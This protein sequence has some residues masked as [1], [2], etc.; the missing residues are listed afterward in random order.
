VKFKYRLQP[1]AKLETVKKMLESPS[2]TVKN[3]EMDK[4]KWATFDLDVKD[5]TKLNTTALFKNVAVTITDGADKGTKVLTAKHVNA[6]PMT[7]PEKLRDYYGNE[8][9]VTLT[10]PGEVVKSNATETKGDTATWKLN[11][12]EFLKATQTE[13]QATYKVK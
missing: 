4:D 13:F 6:K 7:L 5:A 12:D 8:L 9:R 11:L 3:A 1:D 2:V 10:F